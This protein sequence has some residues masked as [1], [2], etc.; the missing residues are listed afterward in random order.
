MATKKQ[1]PTETLEEPMVESQPAKEQEPAVVAEA[2]Q[3]IPDDVMRILAIYPNY[4]VLHIDN[5]GGVYAPGAFI[6]ADAKA[7][8]F[9]NPYYKS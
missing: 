8:L 7:Q 4:P 5:K 2:V 1:I 9:T 3:E 6:P